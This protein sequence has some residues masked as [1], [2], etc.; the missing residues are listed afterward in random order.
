[1][2]LLVGQADSSGNFSDVDLGDQHPNI[3]LT[4]RNIN[5]T[6]LSAGCTGLRNEIRLEYLSLA[7]FLIVPRS[8]SVVF[9]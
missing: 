4:F 9:M 8:I 3:S 5:F 2:L 1:M 7:L 6:Q